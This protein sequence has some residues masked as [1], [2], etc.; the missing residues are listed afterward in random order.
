MDRLKSVFGDG[1]SNENADTNPLFTEV[2]GGQNQ[3]L[4]PS[5]SFEN[6]MIEFRVY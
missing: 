4:C 2:I 3:S 1:E 6:R 5:L